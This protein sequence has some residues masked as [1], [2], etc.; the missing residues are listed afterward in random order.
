MRAQAVMDNDHPNYVGHFAVGKAP[1]L[2]DALAASDLVIA[3]GPRLGEMTTGGYS[4]IDAPVPVQTLV[5]VHPQPEEPGHVYEPDLALTADVESFC[6]AVA[7]WAP[8]A[9][10]RFAGQTEALRSAYSGY[11]AIA[12]LDVEDPLAAM[13]DHLNDVLP[14]DAIITNGAGNYAGW[15]H[16]FYRYRSHGSQLAPTSGSMGYGLPAAIAAAVAA[17]E[18]EVICFAGDGCFMMTCQEMATAAHHGLNL[19]VIVVNNNRYGT[20]RAHQE[21]HYPARI[22]GTALTNPDFCAF[23]KS[24]GAETARVTDL[25][26]FTY[27]LIQARG[28]AGVSLIEVMQDEAMV[29]PGKPL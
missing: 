28:Q 11:G 12:G 29:T 9:P 18:R 4:Y 13:V 20:I 16:R 6:A 15:V 26:E 7:D 8:I 17:P 22:S 19:T 23:A 25:P 10:A 3:L 27:A 21:V 14:A 5:H 24:F 1:Y 2:V